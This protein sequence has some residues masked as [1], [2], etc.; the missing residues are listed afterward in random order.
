MINRFTSENNIRTGDCLGTPSTGGKDFDLNADWRLPDIER[1][2][3][4][5]F[6]CQPQVEHVENLLAALPTV[7]WDQNELMI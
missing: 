1:Q 7:L 2:L 4:I 3:P 5:V 6:W